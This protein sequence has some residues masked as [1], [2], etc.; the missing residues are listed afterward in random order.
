MKTKLIESGRMVFRKLDNKF[1]DKE[2][3]GFNNAGMK[4]FGGMFLLLCL[5]LLTQ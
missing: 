5:F 1:Y 4:L 3:E 2:N